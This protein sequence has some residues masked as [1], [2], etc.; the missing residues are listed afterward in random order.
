MQHFQTIVASG[1]DPMSV[2]YNNEK[3]L[4][5]CSNKQGI[6]FSKYQNHLFNSTTTV[7]KQCRYVSQY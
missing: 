6:K 3:F 4:P 7:F 2:L 5:R 1:I